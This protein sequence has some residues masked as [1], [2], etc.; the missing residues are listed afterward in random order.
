[1]SA[2]N[3]FLEQFGEDRIEAIG[4]EKIGEWTGEHDDMFGL[5][6]DLAHAFEIGD[7]GGDELDADT[8]QR[9]DGDVEQ[10]GQAL[11]RVDLGELAAFEAIERG[12]RDADTARN[13]VGAEAGS[14]AERPQPLADF[15][16]AERHSRLRLRR[17]LRSSRRAHRS[18]MHLQR[19]AE[20]AER[21][22]T[23]RQ[24]GFSRPAHRDSNSSAS[25]AP[26]QAAPEIL[27]DLQADP[28]LAY[29]QRRAEFAS[30]ASGC[31][32]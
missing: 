7:G 17:D 11:Q 2:A 5:F 18:A 22:V 32:R 14:E 21:R 29:P 13:F 30:G 25:C 4:R 16:I 9:R 19:R 15:I 26:A 10:F 12:A 20:F 28:P 8:E 3:A 1:M 27:D 23:A 6:L 31:G 24:S